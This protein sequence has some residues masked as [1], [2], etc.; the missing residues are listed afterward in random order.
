MSEETKNTEPTAADIKA[1]RESMSK[2]YNDE[3]PLLKKR[4]EYETLLADIEEARVK[5]LSM[6]I[7]IAQL[8]SPPPVQEE[9]PL[10][11]PLET[12]DTP[13]QT[14]APEK[15]EGKKRTLKTK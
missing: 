7:R 9:E 15:E 10:D 14:K 2:Y 1:Y 8:T 5:R 3:M 11:E 13:V 12:R 4:K 6:S